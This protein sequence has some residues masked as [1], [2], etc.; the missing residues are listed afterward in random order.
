MKGILVKKEAETMNNDRELEKIGVRFL[1]MEG[2]II[3][4][5]WAR[6]RL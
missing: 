6:I 2:F 1:R 4:R 3:W 5:I